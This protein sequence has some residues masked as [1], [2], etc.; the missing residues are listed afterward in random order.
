MTGEKN[1]LPQPVMVDKRVKA[2]VIGL[3]RTLSYYKLAYG[4]A[5]LRLNPGCLFIATNSDAAYPANGCLLPGAGA[6]VSALETASGRPADVSIGKPSQDLLS[7][8]MTKY[9][10]CPS[11]TCM[12]G[13][14]LSTDVAFGVLGGLSTILVYSGVT[15]K[16]E[17]SQ[18]IASNED[19]EGADASTFLPD[20]VVDSIKDLLVV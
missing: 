6:M 1:D 3:D 4:T 7:T 19:E 11:R 8:V 20:F 13:D 2:V 5:C 12:I 16:E 15:T 18:L 9:N 17:I 10:L 14:R